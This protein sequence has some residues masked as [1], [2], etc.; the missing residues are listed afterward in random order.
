MAS[1]IFFTGGLGFLGSHLVLKL[2]KQGNKLILLIRPQKNKS[3]LDRVIDKFGSDIAKDVEV[4]EGDLDN[5]WIPFQLCNYTKHIDKVIHTAA[6]LDLGERNKDEIWKTNVE[7]TEN[8]LAFCAHYEIPHLIFVSTSY[9]L[10]RNTYELSKAKCEERIEK[11]GVNYTIIKPSI[12]IGSPSDPGPSQAINHV[13][14]TITKLHKKAETARVKIQNGLALPPLELGFRLRGD[15]KASLNVVP[16]NLVV[17][18]IIDLMNNKGTY[19]I[20][21]PNPPSVQKVANELGEALLLNIHI[22]KDFKH[23]PPEKILERVLKPFFT[24]MQGEPE[25]PSV[26]K[27]FRLR[28]GYIKD[29]VKAFLKSSN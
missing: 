18:E 19:Y 6:L 28:K 23:S 13:A 7:G 21:N 11:S 12:V 3:A 5:I 20:T 9:T 22:L 27:S 15:P 2:L 1:R 26:L 24:Y 8:I 16:I 29:T 14:L 17:D 25:F 10:G 4:V